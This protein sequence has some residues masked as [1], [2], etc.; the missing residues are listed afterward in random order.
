MI[1]NLRLEDYEVMFFSFSLS[2]QVPLVAVDSIYYGKLVIT[3]LNIVLYNVF[4][5]GGPYLYGTVYIQWNS[6]IW[7][8]LDKIKRPE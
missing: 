4:G 3:P 7:T 6:L 5:K 2:M 8:P 1:Y